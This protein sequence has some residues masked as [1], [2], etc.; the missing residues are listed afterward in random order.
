MRTDRRPVSDP[1]ALSS[2]VGSVFRGKLCQSVM[3]YRKA[4]RFEKEAVLY[5]ARGKDH[6]IY[7]LERGVV[8]VGTLGKG[9]REIIYDVRREGD[10]VGELCACGHPRRDRAVALEPTEAVVVPFDEVLV[11]LQKNPDALRAFLESLGRT[12]AD[13]YEQVTTLA[14]DD[15]AHRLV[16]T[17]LKLSARL[18]RP[19]EQGVEI[20]SYLTQKEIAQMVGARRERVSTA[21]NQLRR[22]GV[23]QY[24]RGGHLVLD[25]QGLEKFRP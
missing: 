8:K 9:G 11:I 15:L 25:V 12:L 10:V 4:T 7:F 16:K 20:G 21:L 22:R 23:V 3:R 19:G 18:G 6:N 24:S 2:A 14:A 5:E 1:G 17:L 13:A